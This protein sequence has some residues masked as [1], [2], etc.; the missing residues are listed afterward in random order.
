MFLRTEVADMFK[1]LEYY[2]GEKYP[3]KLTQVDRSNYKFLV[4]KENLSIAINAFI[5]ADY[6]LFS[7]RLNDSVKFADIMGSSRKVDAVKCWGVSIF[8]KI[9]VIVGAER[10]C[11]KL[12]RFLRYKR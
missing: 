9:I 6:D 2:L 1:V 11:S 10:R 12:V 8:L 3:N 4:K 5:L 7:N